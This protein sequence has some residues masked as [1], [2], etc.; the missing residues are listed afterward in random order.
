VDLN[1]RLVERWQ[2]ADERREVIGETLQEVPPGTTP[3]V[4]LELPAVFARVLGAL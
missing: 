4:R 3:P 1:A 2:P